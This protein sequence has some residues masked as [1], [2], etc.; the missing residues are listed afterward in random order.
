MRNLKIEVAAFAT[1]VLATAAI[2]L[3]V[4][5]IGHALAADKRKMC[6]GEFTDMPAIGVTIGR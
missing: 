6:S 5:L 3:A 1:S 2:A 4:L